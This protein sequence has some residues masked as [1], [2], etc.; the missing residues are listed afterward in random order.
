MSGQTDT[1]VR[2][3]K[4]DKE[5]RVNFAACLRSGWPTCHGYTMTLDHTQADIAAAVAGLVRPQ[6]VR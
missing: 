1:L 6:S 3:H 2:C 4:C 5:R